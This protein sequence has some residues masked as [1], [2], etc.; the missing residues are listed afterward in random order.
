M[1]KRSEITKNELAI[2]VIVQNRIK[3]KKGKKEKILVDATSVY[4]GWG[5]QGYLFIKSHQLQPPTARTRYIHSNC[6]KK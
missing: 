3:G 6:Q 2:V 1:I 5:T 4:G